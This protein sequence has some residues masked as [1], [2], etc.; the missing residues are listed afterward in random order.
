VTV[1]TFLTLLDA[2]VF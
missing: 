2:V 1:N